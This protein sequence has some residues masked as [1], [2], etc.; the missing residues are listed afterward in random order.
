MPPF[1]LDAGPHAGNYQA[2][3]TGT[4]QSDSDFD[5]SNFG[6]TGSLGY[7]YT[8]NCLFSVKQGLQAVAAREGKRLMWPRA[9]TS[10]TAPSKRRC[11]RATPPSGA[12]FSGVVVARSCMSAGV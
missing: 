3:L 11:Q 8:K 4:G 10:S 6:V 2:T 12:V 9:S 7:H 5:R 1:T